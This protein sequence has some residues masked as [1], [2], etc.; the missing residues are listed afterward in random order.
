M[1]WV[2]VPTSALVVPPDA[3]FLGEPLDVAV[4]PPRPHLFPLPIT[5]AT[6]VR[7]L[8]FLAGA[9]EVEQ[10]R[11]VESGGH[12][13]LLA[14]KGLYY[15]LWRQQVGERRTLLAKAPAA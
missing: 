10:G 7:L 8:S 15:A 1:R 9:V 11:V 13:E 2:Q 3:A 12:E 5:R 14:M 4:E 6:E